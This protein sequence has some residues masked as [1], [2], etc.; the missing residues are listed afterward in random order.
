VIRPR[1]TSTGLLAAKVR[2]AHQAGH[3]IECEAMRHQQRIGGAGRTR[4]EHLQQAALT[5]RF[6]SWYLLSLVMAASSP[7]SRRATTRLLPTARRVPKNPLP[8]V[9][10]SVR[11]HPPPSAR[12]RRILIL[13][14]AERADRAAGP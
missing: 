9:E 3:Q 14:D 1:V 4:G 13:I 11:L 12:P 2:N 8:G 6:S 7:N 10:P 5:R